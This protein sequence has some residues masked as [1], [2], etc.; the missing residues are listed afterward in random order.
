M[1]ERIRVALVGMGKIAHT[2]HLPVIG[3]SSRF[4]LV[5]T[6][7]PVADPA[8][9]AHF[10]DLTLLLKAGVAFEAAILCQPPQ[11]RFQAARLALQSDKHVLLEKPPATSV[12]EVAQLADLARHSGRSLFAA[13]HSR[14]AAGVPLAKEWLK[15][16]RIL[17][18][19]V[20][21]REDV[22]YW[23]PGQRWIWES[24]GLGV[25]DPGINA[26][27]I[28]TQLFEEPL[29]VAKGTLEYPGNREMPIGAELE[30]RSASGV[31]V[32]IV[33][34]W[35]HTGT[36][37]WRLDFDTDAGRMTLSEGGAR[38]Q[39]PGHPEVSGRDQ[40]YE[41]L[42]QRFAALIASGHS[43]ADSEPLRLVTEAFLRC[44]KRTVEPF[45]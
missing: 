16:R 28:L 2:Q 8:D 22:R 10:T 11:V 7:D 13:W 14:Y 43:D 15:D 38:V 41:H 9:V 29:A 25:F 40:E 33:L 23:H 18:V 39:R 42:Y 1:S 3:Q 21:W 37:T 20:E 12:A 5:A 17:G 32:H 35:R 19:R 27:S 44:R 24:G 45:D 4:E 31:P 6:V 36:Q 34:D 30:L 26:L